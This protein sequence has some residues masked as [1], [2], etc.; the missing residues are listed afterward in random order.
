MGKTSVFCH[1]FLLFVLLIGLISYSQST[2]SQQIEIFSIQAPQLDSDKQ[3][4]VYKP[5]NY[6]NSRNAYKVIYMHDAQNLFDRE[7]SFAGEWKVDEI[8]D[9]ISNQKT[10]IVGIE[11]G[12]EKRLDELT[13]FPHE[14]YG[15]GKGDIYLDFIVNILKPYIDKNYRTIS[16]PEHTS[17]MGSSLGGLLSFYAVLKY[18][19]VF[20]N[21]GI[22]SP[23]F[24]YTDDIYS[25]AQA[26]EIPKTQKFY[27]VIGTEESETAVAEQQKMVDL[28]VNK[29]VDE[30][31]IRNKIVNGGKHN[32]DFWN[33]EFLEAY[34]WLVE[35]K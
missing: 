14:K 9:S 33:K 1:I 6:Q 20:G 32:E 26:S 18:P 2:A 31:Q 5:I 7:T 21:A 29:G 17:I 30:N 25:F 24:W 8:L 13:P 11:H 27:F 35:K 19:D 3:I 34:L 28:L 12:N 15:G 16:A 22:F 10:I 23:S 4:W